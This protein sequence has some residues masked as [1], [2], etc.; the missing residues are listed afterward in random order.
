MGLMMAVVFATDTGAAVLSSMLLVVPIALVLLTRSCRQCLRPSRVFAGRRVLVTGGSSGVGAAIAVEFARVGAHVAITGRR[1]DALEAVAGEMRAVAGALASTPPSFHTIPGIDLRIPSNGAEIVRA[2]AELL[3]GLDVL[4]LNAGA[5]ACCRFDEVPP[6]D[7]GPLL[8]SLLAVNFTSAASSLRAALPLLR[9]AHAA[10]RRPCVLVTGTVQAGV[11]CGAPLF[12]LDGAS[13]FALAGLIETVRLEC[14]WLGVTVACPSFVDTPLLSRALGPRGAV[15]YAPDRA[16]A[17]SPKAIAAASVAALARRDR[18]VFFSALDAL[19][20][21]I[22]PWLPGV[23]DAIAKHEVAA[24]S[25][26]AAPTT[27]P[28][29]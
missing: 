16:K 14:P 20:A 23:V 4:V 24:A 11:G 9:A 8:E 1:S 21:L 17:A 2:A 13:K 26:P 15:A 25:T 12:S 19:G 29:E 5:A 28:A 22:R 3:G 18:V 10:G 7:L 6:D 27:T